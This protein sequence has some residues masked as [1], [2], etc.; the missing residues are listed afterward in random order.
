MCSLRSMV[1]DLR[2]V[3]HQVRSDRQPLKVTEGRSSRPCCLYIRLKPCDSQS[4]GK[5]LLESTLSCKVDNYWL[6]DNSHYLV[7]KAKIKECDLLTA[8]K[9][10]C[11]HGCHVSLWHGKKIYPT[12]KCNARLNPSSNPVSQTRVDSS[13]SV[14]CWNCR[15]FASSV[16]YIHSLIGNKPSI[17]VVSEHWLWPYELDKLS[18]ISDNYEA[19]GKADSRLTEVSEGGRGCGG[20]GIIWHRSIGAVPVCDISSD[21]ICAIRF[22]TSN[23]EKSTISVIGVYLPCSDQ[24]SECYR[25]HLV[26]LERIVSESALLGP[27]IILG[28]FNAHLGSLGGLRGRGPA[29]AHGVLLEE[30]MGR[31]SLSATS[32]CSWATGPIYTYVSGEVNTTVDYILADLEATSHLISSCHTF[33]MSDMNSSDHLSI[34]VDLDVDCNPQCE[35]D[36]QS[37]PWLYWEQA[38]KSGE[39][40]E[41]R[42]LVSCQLSSLLKDNSHASPED[43]NSESSHVTK[44]LCDSA[45]SSIPIRNHK[46]PRKWKDAIL[47]AL[48]AQSR[49]ARRAW[50]EEGCPKEGPLFDEKTRLRKEVKKSLMRKQG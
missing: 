41:Y 28:D 42:R 14:I 24:G 38:S 15:G 11:E 12:S 46:R 31:C 20:I 21:R 34:K 27:V 33:P 18:N 10:G 3:V 44:I 36:C 45:L 22:S 7:L 40:L 9:S 23:N 19:T 47:S 17:L 39:N 26:E 48:C 1:C 4:I 5:N 37:L 25:Q 35:E 8:L 30:F 49:N 6:I 2:Q 16:P 29:N 43:I 50:R 13:L 32:L